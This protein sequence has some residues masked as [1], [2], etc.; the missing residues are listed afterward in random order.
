MKMGIEYQVT[1]ATDGKHSVS[2]RGE[3]PEA[4]TEALG[5][6]KDTYA[7]IS[8]SGRKREPEKEVEEEVPI[9]AVHQVPMVR[10]NGKF[11]QFWSCHERNADGGFCSYRPEDR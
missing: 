2:V 7:L 8:R 9:C 5:W 4:L 3:D 6:V 1:L 10:Q 11:G